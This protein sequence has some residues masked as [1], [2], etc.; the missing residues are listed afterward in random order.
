M[1]I[2]TFTEYC[3]T[4][5]T[6]SV[7]SGVP[8]EWAVVGMALHRAGVS[9][10]DRAARSPKLVWE[11]YDPFLQA[12]ASSAV[13]AMVATLKKSSNSPAQIKAALRTAMHSDEVGIAGNPEP[14]TDIVL[15]RTHD[16]RV[17]V[18]LTV[19]RSDKPQ[20]IQLASAGR[21]TATMLHSII[22]KYPEYRTQL[23]AD[24]VRRI[25][26]LPV[27]V[28]SQSNLAR[29]RTESPD[30]I[31]QMVSRGRV[32]DAYSW[33]RWV[34]SNK[35]QIE[36]G[37]LS[38]FEQTP[39]LKEAVIREALTGDLTFADNPAAA[40][41]YVLT[42]QSFTKIDAAYVRKTAAR[43]RI[44]IAPRS[45]GGF[46]SG[47]ARVDTF[48]E[49]QTHGLTEAG[50]LANL[51][52]AMTGVTQSVRRAVE[53]GWHLFKSALARRAETFVEEVLAE[54]EIEII[55]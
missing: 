25:E 11:T 42:Q 46:T 36:T 38:L 33:D 5:V 39:A 9:K 49:S 14:K 2:R 3:R 48:P 54:S 28:I 8:F 52:G 17:S 16:M 7:S 1:S 21:S 30:K 44:R 13:E 29:L 26:Q 51:W 35:A 15:G 50:V 55:L 6:E 40:A 27:K 45:R 43:S 10:A 37:L 47:A 12:Q 31:K 34:A 32:L 22:E 53:S 24:I 4:P 23:L 41:N 19:S 18:K 20:A